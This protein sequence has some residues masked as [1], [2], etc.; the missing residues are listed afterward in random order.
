MTQPRNNKGAGLSQTQL[1]EMY[2]LLLKCRLVDERARVLFR[3]GKFKGNHYSA[4]G[5]EA[6]PV[7]TL[8]G[9]QPSD[10][11]GPSHR[12]MVAALVKGV[13]VK[14]IMAQLYA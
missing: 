3:Q 9:C 14:L 12:D 13:P 2:H 5:Q 8:Y 6:V 10:W 7:G 11:V 1:L 4:V